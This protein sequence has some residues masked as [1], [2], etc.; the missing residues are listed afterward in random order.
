MAIVTNFVELIGSKILLVNKKSKSFYEYCHEFFYHFSR[1]P[2]RVHLI[3][4]HLEFIGNQSLFVLVLSA[5]AIGAV[6]GIE[7]GGIFK[8]FTAQNLMGIA[9]SITLCREI[10]PLLTAILLA[11]RAGSAMAAEIA[12]MKVNEQIDAM[13]SM[14]VAP[15][16]YLVIPRVIASTIITPLLTAIFILIG[17]IGTYV[18]GIIMFQV[19]R[20]IFTA[21][22]L[23]FTRASDL[24][25]RFEKAI[26]FGFAFSLISCWY[27]LNASGG[28]KGVGQ[29]TTRA[30]IASLLALLACDYVIT[31]IQIKFIGR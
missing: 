22:M 24:S 17:I 28:A 14:A 13:E 3:F 16:S 7:I 15:V 26:V 25:A 6:F 9:T 2:Y 4:K 30:V 21:K 11:G 5:F 29:A 8:I 27:G 12:T 10:A 20:G 18:V 1:G 23:S 19:D 31:Y